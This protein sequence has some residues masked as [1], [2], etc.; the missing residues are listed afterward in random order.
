MHRIEGHHI[1]PRK[2]LI[3]TPREYLIYDTSNI[4]TLCRKCHREIHDNNDGISI[5][6]L[7]ALKHKKSICKV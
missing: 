6:T 4:T 2:L 7:S 1:E 3:G 5:K